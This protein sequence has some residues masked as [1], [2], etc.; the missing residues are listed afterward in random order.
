MLCVA[1]QTAGHYRQEV[2]EGRSSDKESEGRSSQPV[3]LIVRLAT[4]T[5]ITDDPM[6]IP[7]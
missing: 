2:T 3:E 7:G 1:P 6:G 5:P 4:T